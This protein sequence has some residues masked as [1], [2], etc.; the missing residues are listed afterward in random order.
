MDSELTGRPWTIRRNST[1]YP[2]LFT[3]TV[4]GT[5]H[6]RTGPYTG[7]HFHVA[8]PLDSDADA[9]LIAAAPEL[10]EALKGLESRF[11]GIFDAY[12]RQTYRDSVSADADLNLALTDARTAIAKAE[13]RS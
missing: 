7:T 3:Y 9:N 1:D 13:G 8:G 4:L 5:N 12:A 6:E 10:L 2:D 11:I